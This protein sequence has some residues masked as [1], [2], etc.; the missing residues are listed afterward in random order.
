MSGQAKVP[1]EERTGRVILL[2]GEAVL[3]GSTSIAPR[4]L[5]NSRYFPSAREGR[6]GAIVADLAGYSPEGVR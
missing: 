2:D 4:S 6:D 3:S 5:V 1:V